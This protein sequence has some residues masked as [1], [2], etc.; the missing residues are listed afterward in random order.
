MKTASWVLRNKETK[1]VICETFDKSKVD[2]L[3]T[4][5]YEAIPILEY[6]VSLNNK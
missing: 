4:E 3:N 1:E 6:L 2:A 5:K